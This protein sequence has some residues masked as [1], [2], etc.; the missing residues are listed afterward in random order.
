MRGVLGRRAFKKMLPSLKQARRMRSLC[1]ECEAKP[2]LRRCRQCK[3]QYC[4]DC[5]E[6]LHAKGKRRVHTYAAI[7]P[8]ASAL[9][10]TLLLCLLVIIYT[11]SIH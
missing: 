3:D 2:A 1:V 7:T 9:G 8:D 4:E 11:P 5:Y 6:A 10:M